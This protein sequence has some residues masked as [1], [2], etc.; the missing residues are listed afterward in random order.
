M[1]T[2]RLTAT[3][4]LLFIA[5]AALFMGSL[6]M[7]NLLPLDDARNGPHRIV[8]WYAG[9]LWTLWL[10]L[11]GLPLTV[12][13]V[14]CATLASSWTGDRALREAVAHVRAALAPHVATLLIAASTLFAGGVLVIVALHAVAN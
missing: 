2:K 3:V 4:E 5:P 8:M 10:L 12:V 7:R 14:G 1:T 11:I 13:L 9:R 6:L